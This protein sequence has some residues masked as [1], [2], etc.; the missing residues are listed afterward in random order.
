MTGMV[1]TMKRVLSVILALILAAGLVS[2]SSAVSDNDK[3]R[4]AAEDFMTG[5]KTLD[6]QKLQS[7]TKE[8][9]K[10]D[11]LKK[12]GVSPELLELFKQWNS[13]ITYE[14]SEPEIKDDK[15]EITLDIVYADASNVMDAVASELVPRV[16]EGSVTYEEEKTDEFAAV[17]AN[18]ILEKAKSETPGDLTVSIT[19]KLEKTDGVW[20]ISELPGKTGE[21]AF[22]NIP[23]F[24]SGIISKIS[25]DDAAVEEFDYSRDLDEDGYWK[26]ITASEYVDLPDISRIVIKQADIDE[27]INDL[28][29]NYTVETEVTDRA[30]EKT[31]SVNIDYVGY[32]DGV[33]FD[34]GS[35]GGQGTTVNIETTNYI[36]GFLPQLVGHKP[37]ETFDINVTFPADYFNEE[38][39]GKAAVFTITV[40]YIVE[41]TKGEWNDQFVEKNFSDE[42]G[43]TTTA[44]V[45]ENIRYFLVED[46]LVE[47]SEFKKDVP[48]M[49]MDYQR[50]SV[51]AYYTEYAA[52]YG[53][54]L[55]EFLHGY[56]Q[57]DGV[58]AFWDHMKEEAEVYCKYYLIYQ[59]AAEKLGYKVSDE[60]IKEYF[61]ETNGSEDYSQIEEVYGLPYIKFMI[62]S[63]TIVEKVAESSVIAD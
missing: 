37:G 7:V 59:A 39:A 30:I 15:A 52:A 9:I 13:R 38:L 33:A 45:E 40:N 20:K 41:L 44:E 16:K 11:L 50:D 19:L 55:E 58:D 51:I 56:A 61:I 25:Q 29:E 27:Q 47:N 14:I 49:M 54:S 10:E 32:V 8:I 17:L 28:L 43:W 34:G 60:E 12:D 26:G 23:G 35:T 1:N 21:I 46:Y 36:D 6:V 42:Y 2:C 4:Q 53:M 24:F 18:M 31:D 63:E 48:E 57:I 62:L 5:V 3:V 22:S